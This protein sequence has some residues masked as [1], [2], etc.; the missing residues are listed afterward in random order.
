LAPA[1]F[2]GLHRKPHVGAA[3]ECFSKGTAISGVTALPPLTTL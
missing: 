1:H 2:R 3:A